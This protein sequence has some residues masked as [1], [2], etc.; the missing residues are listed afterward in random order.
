MRI[1]MDGHLVWPVDPDV[2]A[3]SQKKNKKKE[4]GSEQSSWKRPR[5]ESNLKDGNEGN[6]PSAVIPD[7]SHR[8]EAPMA[9]DEVVVKTSRKGKEKVTESSHLPNVDIAAEDR[10][11]LKIGLKANRL[12]MDPPLST[13][14]R[15]TSG[16][17][18]NHIAPGD[19]T[20]EVPPT[21]SKLPSDGIMEE[22]VNQMTTLLSN[23]LEHH[24]HANQRLASLEEDLVHAKREEE[25]LKA[26]I[27]ALEREKREMNAKVALMERKDLYKL[28]EGKMEGF[29]IA[30]HPETIGGFK[31]LNLTITKK[32]VE[33]PTFNLEEFEKCPDTDDFSVDK[34]FG[35]QDPTS[36]D[37]VQAGPDFEE[38]L[39]TNERLRLRVESRN[40]T[41]EPQRLTRSTSIR[42]EY[43]PTI[44]F[45]IPPMDNQALPVT[46]DLIVD[47]HKDPSS[48]PS[49][50]IV[51]VPAFVDLIQYA[52][53]PENEGSE[54][55]GWPQIRDEDMQQSLPVWIF[56][57]IH[58][59][60]HWSLAIIRIINDGAMLAH[61]D[62]FRG[63][64]DPDVIF[65]VLRTFLCLIM[66]ID[67]ALVQ[68]VIMNLDQ[69]KD[70][71]LCGKHVLQMLVGA[72]MKESRLD[73]CFWEVGLRSIATLDQV[74]SFDLL[75]S[76][77]LSGKMSGLSM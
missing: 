34:F 42:L 72:G 10:R 54:D 17:G 56:V 62:S 32:W 39:I 12:E 53:S 58:G 29:Q 51:L 69:Q 45:D 37:D 63:T 49:S 52:S 16:R 7:S 8:S 4:T 30:N 11:K 57:P 46:L 73:R 9:V 36:P 75:F 31:N 43:E 61:L 41:A 68:T 1:K 76:M 38:D 25:K 40:L 14:T 5:F 28:L 19:T 3:V 77:Y 71:H 65:H 48:L 66:P 15:Q 2:D 55:E 70:G 35:L 50:Q 22:S 33:I 59:N 24:G 20:K 27:E 47:A 23:I 13:P 67:P 60:N 64:H 26:T 6:L 74:M 18:N 21:S 44:L